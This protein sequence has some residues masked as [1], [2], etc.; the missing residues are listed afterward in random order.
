[1]SQLSKGD[2]FAD[3]Q[4]LTAARLNQLVDSGQLLVGAITEQTAMTAN[5]LEATDAVIVSDSGVLKKATIG[6][7]IN[8]NLP[9]A[10]SALTTPVING[11]AN[12]DVVLTPYD[13][14]NVTGKVFTSSDGITAVV[15][16][17]AHGLQTGQVVSVTASN[18]I[19]SGTYAVI[20]LSVDTF[21]YK[22]RQ[23]TPVAASGTCSYTKKATELVKGNKSSTENSFVGGSST[24]LGSQIIAGNES[25]D[26]NLEVVGTMSV[27]GQSTFTVAPK[28][29]TTAINPRLDYFV[30]TRHIPTYTS[31][32]GG[33][34]NLVNIY[35][36]KI[37]YLDITFTPQKAGNKVILTWNILGECSNSGAD[38]V[39]LV[40]RTPNS[41]VGAGVPVALPESVDASNN[42]WSGIATMYDGDDS[43]T[44]QGITVKIFDLNTLDVECTYS[45]HFRSTNNRVVT[46]FLNRSVASAGALDR[47]TG[48]SVG[49]ALEIY[50]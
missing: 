4:Q 16:S 41:G 22:V 2:T 15:T 29:G 49:H 1:M 27:S 39:F 17:V 12:N 48:L 38:V 9:V 33:L 43:T 30:Q 5:T 20:V 19:Y 46:F 42:T 25:I 6:D 7:I 24:I 8:S 26:G 11:S 21:S 44:P 50:T 23:T 40:T 10:T 32:W 36:T 37:P 31:S 35:G 28:L 18:T 14:V 13:G 34:Q 3:G 45:V 47:E